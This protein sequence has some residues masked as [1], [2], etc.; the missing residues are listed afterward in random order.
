MANTYTQIL[1]Q[2]VFA[3]RQRQ[4]LIT[5]DIRTPLEKYITGIV[6]SYK[7]KLIAIACMPDH[8]HILIGM[9]PY[10]SISDL[11][12]NI[13]S[14]SSLWINNEFKPK[15]K[16]FW[17]SG[18]GAFSYSNDDLKKVTNYILNQD[19]HHAESDYYN[20]YVHLLREYEIEYD[21]KYVM[22]N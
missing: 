17:Q 20:E 15:P 3:V 11:V 8:C 21:P 5:K 6:Q 9:K 7:H 10:Q 22:D 16:F 2:I 13:K 4:R 14:S 12:K 18:F 19:Q 1:I